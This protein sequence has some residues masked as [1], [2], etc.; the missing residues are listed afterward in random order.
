MSH[1]ASADKPASPRARST[2]VPRRRSSGSSA[3]TRAVDNATDLV[4]IHVTFG[5]GKPWLHRVRLA[6][7]DAATIADLIV[8]PAMHAAQRPIESLRYVVI[9]GKLG[10]PLSRPAVSVVEQSDDGARLRVC[11]HCEDE[12]LTT[13]SH[14]VQALIADVKRERRRSRCL[15]CAGCCCVLLAILTILLAI[16]LSTSLITWSGLTLQARTA[17]RRIFRAVSPRSNGPSRIYQPPKIGATSLGPP[18]TI[19]KPVFDL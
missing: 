15:N 9:N 17:W 6:D 2:S 7:M 10:L 4:H 11:L 1:D 13:M 16:G 18:W 3:A 12:G 14:P 8:K 5:P 19:P